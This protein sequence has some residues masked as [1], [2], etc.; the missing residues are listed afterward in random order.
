LAEQITRVKQG[1][2]TVDDPPAPASLEVGPGEYVFYSDGRATVTSNWVVVGEERIHLQNVKKATVTQ[3][4]SDKAVQLLSLALTLLFVNIFLNDIK[5]HAP[6]YGRDFYLVFPG[7]ITFISL[8]CM[9]G[10][11]AALFMAFNKLEGSARMLT[12]HG[13]FGDA[14]RVE[15]FASF[16]A[17]Y[18]KTLTGH[19]NNAT[20]ARKSHIF[21]G[22]AAMPS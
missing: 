18:A 21:A 13:S 1:E 12:L 10:G 7:D 6:D 11:F 4:P 2:G 5:N 14:N 15:M 16:D 8:I 9:V 3:V 17:A 19:I 22:N 20:S